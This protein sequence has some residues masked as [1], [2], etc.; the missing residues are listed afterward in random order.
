MSLA[1]EMGREQAVQP[2]FRDLVGT[3]REMQERIVVLIDQVAN[4]DVVSEL[5]QLNDGLNRALVSS[6]N[7]IQLAERRGV[8]GVSLNPAPPEAQEA[9]PPYSDVPSP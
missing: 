6:E 1:L 3:C 4:E 2:L 8:A 9:L 7:A 5:L